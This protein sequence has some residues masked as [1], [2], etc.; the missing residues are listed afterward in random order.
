M[1]Y[2][3]R[4]SF[5]EAFAH[6]SKVAA[7]V[8]TAPSKLKGMCPHSVCT[9]DTKCGDPS[10]HCCP[11][12]TH[13]CPGGTQCLNTSPPTCADVKEMASCTSF[14]CKANFACP[15]K[16]VSTCCK[17]GEMCCPTNTVC[18]LDSPP[19]C[20]NLTHAEIKAPKPVPTPTNVIKNP[21][22]SLLKQAAPALPTSST[23]VPEHPL[24]TPMRVVPRKILVRAFQVTKNAAGVATTKKGQTQTTALATDSQSMQQ[25]KGDQA[26]LFKNAANKVGERTLM[27]SHVVNGHRVTTTE[28]QITSRRWNGAL[29][30][31]T[32]HHS[33][34]EPVKLA[35]NTTRNQFVTDAYKKAHKAHQLLKNA[36]RGAQGIY[37]S[38]DI[39]KKAAN[40]VK[41]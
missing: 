30:T 11:G 28:T 29:K 9:K 14:Q 23:E 39:A 4:A 18:T 32:S 40:A 41:D 10:A 17:G 27:E 21:S 33:N 8:A 5:L 34:T 25:Q 22:A 19:R 16:G 36:Q 3:R 31:V 13:C 2:H 37:Y 1:P 20:R 24:D 7:A 6:G 12:S 35:H 38:G 26:T 15:L